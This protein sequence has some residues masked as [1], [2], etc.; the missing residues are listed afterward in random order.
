MHGG[1]TAVFVSII[2]CNMQSE[3]EAS[4]SRVPIKSGL[5]YK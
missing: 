2:F 1:R 3:Q 4:S 5:R